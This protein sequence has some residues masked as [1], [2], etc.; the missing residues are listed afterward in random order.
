MQ[1]VSE[2]CSTRDVQISPH[3]ETQTR[4][5]VA[6]QNVKQMKSVDG[7]NNELW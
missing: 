5:P 6:E 7:N 2:R 4:K 1:L 3:R